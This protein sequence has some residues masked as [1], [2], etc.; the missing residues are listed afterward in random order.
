MSLATPA[1]CDGAI[2][3]ASRHDASS[4]GPATLA[5]TIL[6]SSVAF[7]DGS[8][9]NVALPALAA[10]LS[11]SPAELAWSI[12]AYLLPLGALTLFGGAVGDHYGRRRLFLLGLAVFLAASVLCTIAPSVSTLLI[13]RALQGVGAACL[14]P[15]SLAILGAAFEGEARGRAIGTWAAAGAV[16]G[17]VGPL[18]GGWLVDSVSWRAIFLLNV[19][20]GAAAAWLAWRHV[21]ESSDRDASAPL[22]WI[23][24]TTA[25]VGLGFL[26]WSLTAAAE[27]SFGAPILT[28]A[29]VGLAALTL[30]VFWKRA[31]ARTQ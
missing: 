1:P 26:T 14:L 10:D 19:P 12:N 21:S 24:A 17:A 28:A 7:I 27:T 20:V 4:N 29:I 2:A 31:E 3:A 30:F 5:A 15:N 16:A 11:T 8:V 6:G 22:D 13:G 25:T 23:G 18:L 9:V